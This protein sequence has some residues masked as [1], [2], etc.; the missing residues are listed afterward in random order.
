MSKRDLPVARH[1]VVLAPHARLA[2]AKVHDL[3][4]ITWARERTGPT[5][6]SQAFGDGGLGDHASFVHPVYVSETRDRSTL[7]E[8]GV[9]F[10]WEA[11]GDVVNEAG[12]SRLE[13]YLADIAGD[14]HVLRAR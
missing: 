3:R 4:Y 5:E 11:P 14:F 9:P 2:L 7:D 1:A 6:G 10:G 13:M 12:Y 8:E